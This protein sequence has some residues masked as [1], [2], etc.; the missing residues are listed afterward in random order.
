MKSASFF[1]CLLTFVSIFSISCKKDAEK[2]R[3]LD[4]GFYDAN[5]VQIQTYI[6]ANGITNALPAGK[7]TY[8]SIKNP[9]PA[10]QAV[11]DGDSVRVHFT[12]RLLNGSI[13]DTTSRIRNLPDRYLINTSSVL[14][15]LE[16]A[17]RLMREGETA[18]ILVPSY[19]ALTNNSTSNIPPYSVLIYDL[20]LVEVRSEDEQIADYITKN[21]LTVLE[22]KDNARHILSLA[23]TPNTKP[24]DGQE[25]RVCYTGRLLNGTRFDQNQDS[26]FRIFLAQTGL[27]AGFTT[28][29]RL[30]NQGEKATFIFPSSVAYGRQGAGSIPAYAPLLFEL[31]YVKNERQQMK[32]HFATN[33]IADT[34]YNASS[35]YHKIL[36]VGTGA[37]ASGSS[38]V[39]IRYKGNLL[40]GTQIAYPSNVLPLN[41]N[42]REDTFVL[43]DATYPA[44]PWFVKGFKEIVAAMKV[45]EKRRIWIPSALAFGVDS[46]LNIPKR[47]P[48]MFEVELKSIL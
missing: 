2:Q 42:E 19:R 40:N 30:M 1:Y 41:Q 15:G 27:I 47:T 17:L 11:N 38:R 5:D 29:L 12:I 3:A 48:I 43:S 45:G 18:T 14:P 39:V 26:T 37:Q 6:K 22:T 10:A 36:A 21:A 8:Y 13:V 24:A 44:T 23:G 32:E 20:E 4:Q 33:V 28:S 35:S 7:G 25:M 9:L 34:V 16:D 46:Y 31:T